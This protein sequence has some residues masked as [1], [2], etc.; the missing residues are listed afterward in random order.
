MVAGAGVAWG[1]GGVATAVERGGALVLGGGGCSHAILCSEKSGVLRS[2]LAAVCTTV[3]SRG[4]LLGAA[5]GAGRCSGREKKVK[6]MTPS[7]GRGCVVSCG[8]AA[9]AAASENGGG[10]GSGTE[11]A[12]AWW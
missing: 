2:R 5:V 8:G 7:P 10:A 9:T 11:A 6:F 12:A 3:D 4:L 1:A